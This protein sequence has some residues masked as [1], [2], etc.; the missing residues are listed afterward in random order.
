RPHRC[1][2]RGVRWSDR[3]PE[4]TSR[5]PPTASTGSRAISRSSAPAAS[6]G[7]GRSPSGREHDDCCVSCRCRWSSSRAGPSARVRAPSR[8][9]RAEIVRTRPSH[10]IDLRLGRHTTAAWVYPGD[11]GRRPPLMVHGFRGDH[12]GLDPIAG[13]IRV[14]EVTVPDLPCLGRTPPLPSGSGLRSF[15]DYLSAPPTEIGRQRQ[16]KPIVV[17]HSFGSILVSHLPASHPEA[18]PELVLINP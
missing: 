5:R 16:A 4:P 1:W 3:R 11:P 6:A 13:E 14:G 17:G 2:P 8:T 15:V 7:E 12:H 18:L 9:E 10:R